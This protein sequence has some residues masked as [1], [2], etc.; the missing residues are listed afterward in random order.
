MRKAPT[1]FLAYPY[2]GGG[3]STSEDTH[4][5]TTHRKQQRSVPHSFDDLCV[6]RIS[7]VH[8]WHCRGPQPP[9]HICMLLLQW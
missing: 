2:D 6:H 5:P 7:S 1:H 4:S 9:C 3:V 8:A